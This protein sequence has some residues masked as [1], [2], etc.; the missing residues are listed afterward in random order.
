MDS[1]G[2]APAESE[3]QPLLAI[4]AAS[5]G[6][7]NAS[8]KR[9]RTSAAIYVLSLGFLFLFLAYNSLQNY[10]TSLLPNG[11]GNQSLA[12]LYVSV[13][14]FVFTAPSFLRHLGEKWTMVLGGGCYVVYMATLI[15]VCVCESWATRLARN[16]VCVCE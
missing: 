10:V 12:V 4:N 13:C 9:A 11:L 1:S 6:S 2:L 15:K 7:P 5:G 16:C 14:V 8:N 3:T